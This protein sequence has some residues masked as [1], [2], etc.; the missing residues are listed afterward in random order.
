MHG[1]RVE[2]HALHRLLKSTMEM[3]SLDDVIEMTKDFRGVLTVDDL[4]ISLLD[5]CA[6]TGRN[7]IARHLIDQ[8]GARGDCYTMVHVLKQLGWLCTAQ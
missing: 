7:D 5:T 6:K 2:G 3:A 8:C 4:D 1:S